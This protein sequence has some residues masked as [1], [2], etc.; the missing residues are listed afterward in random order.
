MEDMLL[1]VPEV[2]AVLKT[3]V[4]YVYKLQRTGLIKFMKIGRLKCRRSTLEAFLEK[5]DGFD[6]SNPEQ[7]KE[8]KGCE[9]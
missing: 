4:D 2:A 6:V 5:Y 9:E 8:L 7:I 1:T 3:N